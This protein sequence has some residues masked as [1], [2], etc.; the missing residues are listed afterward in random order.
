M[1]H[2]IIFAPL[3]LFFRL[4]YHQMAW[5]YDWVAWAVSLG[6]WKQWV[7]S[8]IPYI[9]GPTALELGHG[10]GHLQAKLI[11]I[12]VSIMG[13]DIS[14]QMGKIARKRLQAMEVDYNLIN[15]DGQQIPFPSEYF[16]QVAVTFPTEYI[17]KPTTLKEIIRVLK[18]G[19][20]LVIIPV[21]WINGKTILARAAAALFRITG[22]AGDWDNKYL[23]PFKQAG[24]HVEVQRRMVKE[25]TVLILT[26]TKSSN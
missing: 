17:I 6:M 14:R 2:S 19:G 12:G 22:Q 21:A 9:K 11:S 7:Y 25:S 20:G 18:P 26:A 10:P 4:L 23:D 1:L 15:G 13:M 8:V 24:F 5:T 16:D 3:R